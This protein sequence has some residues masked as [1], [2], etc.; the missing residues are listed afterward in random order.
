MNEQTN[1]DSEKTYTLEEIAQ[2]RADAIS[3]YTNQV[4]VL[5]VQAEF[6]KLQ[7]DIE[8]SRTRRLGN[9]IKQAQMTELPEP[10]E[11]QEEAPQP[12]KK[13]RDLKKS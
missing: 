10:E 5:N 6:E 2:K 7:A 8:E 11:V 4:A 9:I 1:Q 12:A 13:P 3:F